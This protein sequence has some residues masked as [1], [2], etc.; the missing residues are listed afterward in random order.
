MG[1]FS[2]L[3]K[4]KI[5]ELPELKEPERPNF[6]EQ[7]MSFGI[8]EESADKMDLIKTK[9]DLINSKLDNIDRRLMELERLAEK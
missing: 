1:I 9:L 5:E 4:N 6:T 8:R 2:F 3:K 7:P